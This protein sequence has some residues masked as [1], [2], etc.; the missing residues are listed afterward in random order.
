MGRPIRRSGAPDTVAAP[1]WRDMHRGNRARV[2]LVARGNASAGGSASKATAVAVTTAAV[3]QPMRAPARDNARSTPAITW[4]K[5]PLYGV[6]R[7]ART[8]GGHRDERV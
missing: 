5:H 8:L 4:N 1:H 6:A 3:V 7:G 2:A